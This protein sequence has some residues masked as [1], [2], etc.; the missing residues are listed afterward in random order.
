[1]D[2]KAVIFDCDGTLLD[3]ERIYMST[4]SI[5]GER[6]GYEI[7]EEMLAK[8]R[9]RSGDAAKKII[10]DYMGEEFPLQM[11][12]DIRA[13]MNEEVFYQTPREQLIK[14]GVL[15][16]FEWLKEQGIKIGVASARRYEKTSEHLKHTG[17]FDK[18]EVVLGRD[19]VENSK[20][21]PDLFLKAAEVM[22]VTSEECIVVGDTPADLNAACAAGMKMA[23]VPD[24]I[25]ADEEIKKKAYVILN[26]IDE[27]IGVIKVNNC[28]VSDNN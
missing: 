25:S 8:T 10:L 5:V 11:F 19:L 12:N 1:M 3:T 9:G 16:L 26:Q 7:S 27:L 2:I 17:L 4:W 21:A 20:P 22:G 14:P 28:N 18:A 23:F 24:S 15:K 13:T 6:Y